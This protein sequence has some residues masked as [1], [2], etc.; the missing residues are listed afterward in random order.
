MF[1]DCSVNLPSARPPVK[2]NEIAIVWMYPKSKSIR[3]INLFY[4][5]VAL[6]FVNFRSDAQRTLYDDFS[7]LEI[8]PVMYR[9]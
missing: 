1:T 2:E 7:E 8:A 9:E 6:K 5:F 4:G 3:I